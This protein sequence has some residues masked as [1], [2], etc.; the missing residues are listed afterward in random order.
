MKNSK[1]LLIVIAAAVL[2]KLFL[3]TFAAIHAPASKFISD[4]ADYLKTA[5]VLSSDGAFAVSDKDGR[6]KYEVFRTPGYP[7]FLAILHH[8][9]KI[10]LTGVILLQVFLTILAALIVYKTALQIDYR[11]AILSAIIVLYDLPTSVFSL[12]LITETLYAFLISLFIFSFTCYLKKGSIKLAILPAF[13]LAAATYVRPISYYLGGAIAIFIIY[14]NIP[15]N[16]RKALIH[17]LIF[18][19]VVY[20]LL[21]AWQLRNYRCCRESSFA[22]VSSSNFKNFGLLKDYSGSEGPIFRRYLVSS[23]RYINVAWRSFLSIMT[24]PGTLKYFDSRP[25]AIVGKILAYPWMVFWVIGFLVGILRAGRNIYYQFML[26][27]ILYFVSVTILNISLLAGERFR[28]PIVSCI[29]IISAS[30]W[31]IMPALVKKRNFSRFWPRKNPCKIN[32]NI[33]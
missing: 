24:R 6:L 16:F 7:I 23:P 17:A 12:M 8:L 27:I 33:I 11:I 9:I 28:V 22:G 30:G 10:P 5:T 29:A 14:A 3:F 31:L 13:I 20:S 25:L 2:I 1:S 19:V 15:K 21:G 18:L 32:R 4:S 26:F